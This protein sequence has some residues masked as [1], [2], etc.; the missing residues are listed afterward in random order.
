MLLSRNLSGCFS[1]MFRALIL[2]VFT[3]ALMNSTGCSND[4]D[5]QQR[6]EQVRQA[7]A[8]AAERAKP[9]IKE[10][11]R[12]LNAAA[13]TAAEE[14]HAA[15]QGVREGWKRGSERPLDLNSASETELMGLPGITRRD[16]RRII[17]GRP[18]RGKHDLVTRKII[19]SDE[20]SSIRNEITTNP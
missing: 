12:D 15:A 18:Y 10:A 8:K 4:K 14:A 17:A 7:A 1:D 3:L 5:R 2:G 9:A 19:S 16:A 13:K 20:Y 11:G 6:D